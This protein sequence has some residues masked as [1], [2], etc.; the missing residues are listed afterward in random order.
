MKGRLF[1][2]MLASAVGV[3]AATLIAAVRLVLPD[4][5]RPAM[6]DV[7]QTLSMIALAFLPVLFCVAV[8]FAF[9][10][11]RD[12]SGRPLLYHLFFA[13][14]GTVA[15]LASRWLYGGPNFDAWREWLALGVLVLVACPVTAWALRARLMG[16]WVAEQNPAAP[17]RGPSSMFLVGICIGVVTLGWYYAKWAAL[18]IVAGTYKLPKSMVF[19]DVDWIGLVV[20]GVIGVALVG[21]FVRGKRRDRGW[22]MT[23]TGIA[24][25]LAMAAVPFTQY[26][27]ELLLLPEVYEQRVLPTPQVHWTP[28]L[29]VYQLLHLL[30]S[31][32]LLFLFL[33]PPSTAVRRRV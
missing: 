26:L 3:F 17:M 30:P 4:A 11:G 2:A 12:L 14:A 21:V 15:W 7:T 5:P 20:A 29:A 24:F 32:A 28:K 19:R 16:Y 6:E 22:T 10:L 18:S 27:A 23:R 8:P 1:E 31:F 9:R 25:V 13:I 33:H